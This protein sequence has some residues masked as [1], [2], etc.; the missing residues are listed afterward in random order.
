MLPSRSWAGSGVAEDLACLL[1][2][3]GLTVETP[4]GAP[5]VRTLVQLDGDVVNQVCPAR[6]AA[7]ALQGEDLD[8]LARAHAAAVRARLAALGGAVGW[9]RPL[10]PALVWLAP[11]L[12]WLLPWWTGGL[13]WSYAATAA[14]HLGGA[15]LLRAA[16]S[17]TARL[18]FR[19][20]AQ[21][22]RQEVAGR[23]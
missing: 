22:L 2:Q 16:P 23:G 10:H 1:A 18:L 6:L 3:G 15:A 13:S 19:K 8:A 11:G 4:A 9:F 14:M 12:S 5:V 7:A 17:W 21:R 20:A